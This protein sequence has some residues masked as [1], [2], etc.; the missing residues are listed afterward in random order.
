MA[1]RQALYSR[2][3]TSQVGQSFHSLLSEEDADELRESSPILVSL[4]G[5]I[6]TPAPPTRRA[7]LSR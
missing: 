6:C 4:I 7:R 5:S 3:R 2:F 1:R